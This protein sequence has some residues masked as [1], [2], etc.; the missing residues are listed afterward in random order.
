MV[1]SLSFSDSLFSPMQVFGDRRILERA[2]LTTSYII[3]SP[4]II[5]H[6]P[7]DICNFEY[8]SLQSYC[9][10]SY[11]NS[12]DLFRNHHMLEM[13]F[14]I[15]SDNHYIF[16][17]RR[18]PLTNGSISF[19]LSKEEIVSLSN[20]SSNITQIYS[21]EVGA[22]IV[23]GLGH[24]EHPQITLYDNGL[25]AGVN[26]FA[27]SDPRGCL[28]DQTNGDVCIDNF[29][30]PYKFFKQS[31]FKQ[32]NECLPKTCGPFYIELENNNGRK[33]CFFCGEILTKVDKFMVCKEC[34]RK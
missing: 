5:F 9:E 10:I 25:Y 33:E 11:Y 8:I 32:S 28:R 1:P 27:R 34:D 31:D 14:I 23:L 26:R 3:L 19:N 21:M 12:Y 6:E 16:L 29:K 24:L 20:S 17:R 22:R 13:K 30:H 7:V 15:N 2:R 4:K 18:C